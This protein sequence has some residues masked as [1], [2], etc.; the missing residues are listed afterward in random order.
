[1]TQYKRG[2]RIAIRCEVQPGAFP[3]EYLVTV[4][5]A[6][7]PVSGFA[8]E[9]DLMMNGST[10]LLGIVQSV[11]PDMLE[12]WLRGSFFTTNGLA[13]LKKDW[14]RDNVTRVAA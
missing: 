2:E 10:S 3:G 6:A 8:R 9:S 14:A 5:T 11:T 12:V 13:E 1:M 7:G 4:T